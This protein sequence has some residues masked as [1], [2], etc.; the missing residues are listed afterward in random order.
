M[1]AS[2]IEKPDLSILVLIDVGVRRLVIGNV[3]ERHARSLPAQLIAYKSETGAI[4]RGPDFLDVVV[5]HYMRFSHGEW[6]EG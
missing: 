1:V 4:Q 6:I 3:V 2:E 5:I